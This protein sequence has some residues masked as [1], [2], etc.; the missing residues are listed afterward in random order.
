MKLKVLTIESER[1]RRN[2]VNINTILE[3][4]ILEEDKSANGRYFA[5]KHII[6]SQ[7]NDHGVLQ[8]TGTMQSLGDRLAS[9]GEKLIKCRFIVVDTLS[10]NV[11]YDGN[12]TDIRIVLMELFDVHYKEIMFV[13]DIDS[14]YKLRQL[15]IKTTP[16]G[17]IGMD[18]DISILSS[19]ED[20][21]KD[22]CEDGSQVASTV[23][24]VNFIKE[25]AVF[26][27]DAFKKIASRSK[28]GLITITA[29]GFDEDGNEVKLSSKISKEILVLPEVSSW[30]DKLYLKLGYLVSSL[31]EEGNNENS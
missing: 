1:V 24:E 11:Y 9:R 28:K 10:K 15:K 4:R 18:D 19:Q 5:Y 6:E 25:G 3:N 21:F 16:S 2:E 27:K 14:F 7:S 30:E 31:V 23:F 22:L 12:Q 13:T 17:Q 8:Q 20:M 29:K 26:K